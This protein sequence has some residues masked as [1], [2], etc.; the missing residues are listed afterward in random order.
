MTNLWVDR[1]WALA[2]A[3]NAQAEVSDT[4]F[5]PSFLARADRE[6]VGRIIARLHADHGAVENVVLVGPIRAGIWVLEWRYQNGTRQLQHL[7]VEASP[8]HRIGALR[9]GPPWNPDERDLTEW[10]STPFRLPFRGRWH[11]TWGGRTLAENYHR[12]SQCQRYAYDFSIVRENTYCKGGG[13]R[14]E[15]HFCYG[16]DILA[17]AEG[18]ILQAVDGIPDNRPWEKNEEQPV[19]NLVLI[20]HAENEFSLLAHLRK[21]S[22]AVAVGE[23]VECGK[24]IGECGNSGRSSKPHLHFHVQDSSD[25]DTGR[26]LPPRFVRIRTSSGEHDEGEPTRGEWVE[27]G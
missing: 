12:E 4:L 24:K 11:V 20:Q 7:G 17:P 16:E 10:A 1:S 5:T 18:R 2:R 21:G 8:P 3:L 22:V 26:G 14:N 15:D 9:F 25:L 6:E 23:S 19:G 27:N 13:A